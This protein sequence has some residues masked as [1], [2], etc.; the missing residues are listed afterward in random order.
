MGLLDNQSQYSYY[1]TPSKYGNYQFVTLDNII[2]GFMIAYVGE[3]KVI[4]KINR[5]DVQFHAMRAMQ[6]LSYDVFRSIKSQEIEVPS[7][8]KMILPHDYVNYVKLTKVDKYGT[9]LNIYPTGKTSNPFAIE[10]GD[11]GDYAYD[12]T[13]TNLKEQDDGSNA[14]QA[15]EDI[16]PSEPSDAV[17]ASDVNLDYRGRR[18]GLDPQHAHKHGSF[19]IDYLRGYIHFSSSLAGATIILKYVSDGLGTD[20]EM[21]VHKFCEEAIY[22]WI[23]YG[24]VSTRSNIPDAIVQRFRREKFNESRKAKIRLSNIKIEDFTQ[25][26]RGMGKQ[27]K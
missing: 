26:I 18:Y 22:K 11:S 5:T 25:I 24:V 6:E 7:S 2:S 16:T 19:Y 17:D 8:L 13:N 10:Q 12:N 15:Y 27:I 20:E 1:T 23:A 9:E 14:F 4:T 3:N 21:V